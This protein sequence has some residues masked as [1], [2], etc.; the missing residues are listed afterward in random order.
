[1]AHQFLAHL[2]VPFPLLKSIA[3]AVTVF[4]EGQRAAG[5]TAFHIF[6]N[7]GFLVFDG[8]ILPVQ[9]IIHG[10][11]GVSGDVKGFDQV[12]VT[13]WVRQGSLLFS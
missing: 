13:S 12:V 5:K 7:D 8:Y 9:L 1:M 6:L 11:P 3:G 10:D 4:K 2:L